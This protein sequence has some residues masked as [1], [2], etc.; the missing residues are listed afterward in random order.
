ME[1][2]G[3]VDDNYQQFDNYHC[4][5]GSP[6]LWH[7]WQQHKQEFIGGGEGGW[8]PD[9][10]DLY[11]APT[12]PAENDSC[13]NGQAF[14]AEVM[15]L[16]CMAIGASPERGT[17]YLMGTHESVQAGL[18]RTSPGRKSNGLSKQFTHPALH[19]GPRSRHT[20]G[21]GVACW[22]VWWSV[23]S[24]AC[25]WPERCFQNSISSTGDK[26]LPGNQVGTIGWDWEVLLNLT[27][28]KFSQTTSQEGTRAK[29]KGRTAK[30]QGKTS[31]P[32]WGMSSNL[33]FL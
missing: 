7:P 26:G 21:R 25:Q 1:I 31:P 18:F 29:Q 17:S 24:H 33:H 14:W 13:K 19:R 30:E 28:W 4:V 23:Q 6:H 12:L 27:F 16:H 3:M 8:A 10:S 20:K 15:I 22:F 11:L 5:I 2:W 9:Q 32:Q